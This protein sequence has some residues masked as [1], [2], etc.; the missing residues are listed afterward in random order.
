MGAISGSNEEGY[1][2][3]LTLKGHGFM[4]MQEKTEANSRAKMLIH[5]I[6][7]GIIKL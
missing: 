1:K 3:I 5:L 4:T 7:K 2:T 6:E